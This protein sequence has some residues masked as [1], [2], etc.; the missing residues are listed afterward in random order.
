[1]DIAV[2]ELGLDEIQSSARAGRLVSQL[3]SW[4]TLGAS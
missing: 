3:P 2:L 1:L 4:V